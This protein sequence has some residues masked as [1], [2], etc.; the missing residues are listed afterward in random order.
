MFMQNLDYQ[1]LWGWDTG[2][3]VIKKKKKNPTDDP[4][5]PAAISLKDLVQMQILECNLGFRT[6]FFY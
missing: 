2:I 1:S 6:F 4:N 5:V 3:S